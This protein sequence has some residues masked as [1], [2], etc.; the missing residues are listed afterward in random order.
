MSNIYH[1]H[2]EQLINTKIQTGAAVSLFLPLKWND[3]LPNKMFN[4]LV[5]AADGL[6]A[7][8]GYSKLS[9]ITPEWERW[10][11]QGTVTLAIFHYN[12]VTTLI[13]LPTKM[14]PRVVVAN[15]FHIKPIV[16]ASNEF[17]DGLLLHFH[18]R[19][20]SLF[21]VNKP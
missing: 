11:K 15:S 13:P 4:S 17:V 1:D 3:C 6:L 10:M 16:T 14:E 12:G 5:K 2:L 21:R 9:I 7:K 18:E 8:S 19:G 20:A